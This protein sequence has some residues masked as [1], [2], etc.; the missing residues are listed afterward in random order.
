[1]RYPGHCILTLLSD[2]HTQCFAVCIM[3]AASA[4]K[5]DEEEAAAGP[6]GAEPQKHT[7][8][9]KDQAITTTVNVQPITMDSDE[10]GP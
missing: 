6:A 8:V 9:F 3:F 7:M 4:E 2:M 10:P 1:M 5:S